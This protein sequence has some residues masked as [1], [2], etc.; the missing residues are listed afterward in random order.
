[1]VV[2]IGMSL[3]SCQTFVTDKFRQLEEHEKKYFHPCKK[4]SGDFNFIL[5]KKTDVLLKSYMEWS[6][7]LEGV[8]SIAFVSPLG[9]DL[10]FFKA[11][12][13]ELSLSGLDRFK[14]ISIL[15]DDDG[16]LKI[17]GRWLGIKSSEVPCFLKG[18][19]PFEWL[20]KARVLK[21]EDTH[22]VVHINDS[23]RHIEIDFYYNKK[24][25]LEKKCIR[26]Y[27][28]IF[29]IFKKY[30]IDICY[31]SLA[32]EQVEFNFNNQHRVR[33]FEVDS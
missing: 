30:H 2:L 24:R 29:W 17:G 3:L 10:L 16:F 25:E 21:K 31:D 27:W 19:L 14:N 4:M 11:E 5:S 13:R 26:M 12:N 20:D 15:V 1:V 18:E 9:N 22:D 33:L 23:S 32:E 8:Y 7:R 28:N 6:S